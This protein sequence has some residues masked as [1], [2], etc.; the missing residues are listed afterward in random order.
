MP[1]IKHSTYRS[2]WWLR[3]ANLATII[4]SIFRKVEG[5]EYQRERIST[6]DD[7]FID[8]DWL[9]KDQQQLAILLH[10]LEGDS[11]RAYMAGMAKY[12]HERNWDV[13]AYNC[14]GCSGEINRQPRLYHHGDTADV[15]TVLDHINS[16]NDYQKITLIGFSMGGSLILN[17]L[18]NGQHDQP[19]NIHSAIVYSVPCD[20]KATA[21]ELSQKGRGFYR[22]R[23]LKKLS[24]KIK[25]KAEQFPDLIDA[26]GVEDIDN[27]YDF[28]S[29]Y[30]APIHGFESADAFYHHASAKN[31]LQNI[32]VPTLVVNAANDPMFSEES[33]PI[34]IAKQLN[35]VFLEIPDHGGHVGF[36]YSSF[37]TNWMEDRAYQ[38]VSDLH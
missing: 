4:P 15:D 1:L 3:N 12:F 35:N 36:A 34:A 17:Y 23:F 38:F 26:Q 32:N 19:A 14:R 37:K 8:L 33:Y 2:P 16:N 9:K 28:E 10:G 20:L 11:S 5:V 13:V 27:F 29:K 6:P 22:K 21:L 24:V 30:T 25:S 31:Y 7:D 18:G